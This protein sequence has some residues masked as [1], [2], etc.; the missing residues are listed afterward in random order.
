MASN[1]GHYHVENWFCF[2][3]QDFVIFGNPR[4]S[5]TLQLVLISLEVDSVE[6]SQ[7]IQERERER[8]GE[9]GM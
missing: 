3:L 5:I 8:E 1:V 7:G 4:Q 9:R 2:I 6:L